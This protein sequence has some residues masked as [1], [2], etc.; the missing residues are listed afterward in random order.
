[1]ARL[2]GI[3]DRVIRRSKKILARIEENQGETMRA[4]QLREG[5]DQGAVGHVQLALFSKPERY[6]IEKIQKIDI[7]KMTPIDALNCLH[8][9]Q[10][11]TKTLVN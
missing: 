1:V 9:L 2:A 8:A 6:L 7:S 5:R 10:E 11:K 4:P 3:P